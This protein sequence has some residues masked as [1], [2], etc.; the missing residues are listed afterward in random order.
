MRKGYIIGDF[1]TDGNVERM[2]AT[3]R[4]LG[5]DLVYYATEQEAEDRISDGEI[6]YAETPEPALGMPELK[7]IHG[8]YAGA[9]RFVKTGLF[10]PGRIMYTNSSGAYG[11][12]ISEYVIM[13]TLMMMRSIT[14][15]MKA[16]N[17]GEWPGGIT[18]RSIYGSR[19]S[20]LGTGDIGRNTAQRFRELGAA[21]VEGFSRSG[22]AAE[23]FDSVFRIDEI[24]GRLG[25]TDVLVL[26]LPHTSET[27][28][29][30]DDTLIEALPD[31][32]YVVNV[33]RGSAVDQEALVRA[34]NEGRLAGAALDVMEP[35]PLPE[36][37]IL[38]QAENL[39]LTPH[40]SGDMTMRRTVD[41]TVDI[42]CENL[43]RFANGE[44]L[45]NLVDVEAG[46]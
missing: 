45:L 38:R 25:R 40:I 15:Y 31:T 24:R 42:F 44:D 8:A 13:V 22:K 9:D 5:F 33:G 32:A 2:L 11:R 1:L 37:H 4:K 29:I 27:A 23:G 43:K 35:E 21:A 6:L 41:I 34:L 39:V 36:E 18:A 28:G 16:V 12:A 17:R 14:K 3:G 26:C 30:F 7:W 19:I 10:G 46:Y 20:V